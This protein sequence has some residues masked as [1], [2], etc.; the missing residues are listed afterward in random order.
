MVGTCQTDRCGAGSLG[1][2]TVKAD[3]IEIGGHE[4]LL[5][6]HNTKP[7]TYAIWANNNL[8][9]TLSNFRSPAIGQGGIK[10]KI[11]NPLTNQRER[12]QSDVNVMISKTI[13]QLLFRNIDK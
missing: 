13:V 9:K 11:R 4:S 10:R 12:V 2:T 1:K 8:V 7:L 3:E 6:Q 5:Y